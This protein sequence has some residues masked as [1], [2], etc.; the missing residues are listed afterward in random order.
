M[1]NLFLQERNRNY[2]VAILSSFM[3][4]YKLS[5]MTRKVES[6]LVFIMATSFF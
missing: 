5:T 4:S 2:K 6:Q 1:R 3:D